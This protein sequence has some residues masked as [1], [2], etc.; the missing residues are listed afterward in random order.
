MKVSER[1]KEV[2]YSAIRKLTPYAD[3][4]KENGKKIYHLNIGEPDT[5][6]PKE[7][8]TA[9]KNFDAN[10]LGYAPS[11]GLLDLR[12]ATSE[13]YK[14]RGIDFNA[15]DEIVI[16][17]GASEALVFAIVATTDLGDKILTCNPFY[18]NYYTIFRQLGINPQTFDT[19]VENGYELP[20]YETII[21]SVTEDTKAILLSNPSNPTGAVYTE[22]EIKVIAKVA[23]D[24]DLFIIADEVYREYVFDNREFMSFAELE[25]I[26]DRLILLDSISKR[27]GACGARIGSIASKNK[28]LMK[29]IVKLATGRLAAPTMEQIGATELYNVSDEYFKEINMEYEKRRNCIYEELNKIEGVTV[30]PSKGAFYVMPV[31]PVDDAED[32][33]KWLLTDFDVDGETVMVAPAGGFYHNS[34]AGKNQVRLAFVL[35]CEEIKKSINILNQGIIQYNKIKKN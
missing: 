6:T 25:G 16:T 11:K 8:F 14:N 10:R 31:L 9:I 21:K 17:A 28:E 34:D 30:Y 5:A 20:D 29:E 27:F 2:P 7:F 26:E 4:A 24:K 35:N 15:E 3:A 23:K 22:E 1:V 32:F 13:Y 19:H 18:S 12:M 33:A